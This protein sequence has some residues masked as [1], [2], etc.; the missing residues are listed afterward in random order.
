M[1]SSLSGIGDVAFE[2]RT[3]DVWEGRQRNTLSYLHGSVFQK[4]KRKGTVWGSP[5]GHGEL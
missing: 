5:R 4:G 2:S 1:H 3:L